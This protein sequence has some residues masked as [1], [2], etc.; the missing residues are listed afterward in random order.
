M[1]TV[2]SSTAFVAAKWLDIPTDNMAC[3]D[4]QIPGHRAPLLSNV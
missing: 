3:L 4:T 1:Y 2:Y